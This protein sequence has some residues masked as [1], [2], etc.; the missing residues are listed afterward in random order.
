GPTTPGPAC[1]QELINKLLNEAKI[2]KSVTVKDNYG[3]DHLGIRF[4]I[5]PQ[6]TE[7]GNIIGGYNP[8]ITVASNG[9]YLSPS[10]IPND[11]MYSGGDRMWIQLS[12]LDDICLS[13]PPTNS[14]LTVTFGFVFEACGGLVKLWSFDYS[15][16]SHA[17]TNTPSPT[18]SGP[19]TGIP[20][21]PTVDTTSGGPG[22]NPYACGNGIPEP[23][24]ECGEAGLPN[25]P[26]G[27]TCNNCICSGTTPV[28][29]NN[30]AEGGEQCGEPTLPA[31]PAGYFCNNCRCITETP[32]GGGSQNI[33]S[34]NKQVRTLI[35]G[36]DITGMLITT[37]IED[38]TV[39]EVNQN[40]IIRTTRLNKGSNS[41]IEIISIFDRNPPYK[42]EQ[43][44]Y[45]DRGTLRKDIRYDYDGAGRLVRM[46]NI[47]TGSY[48]IFYNFDF[49]NR[50]LNAE[51]HIK[52]IYNG[53]LV[54]LVHH[55]AFS[56]S[57]N[58]GDPGTVLA[59][60]Y[61]GRTPE[62]LQRNLAAN[63]I[64]NKIYYKPSQE[65]YFHPTEITLTEEYLSGDIKKTYKEQLG[66]SLYKIEI[67]YK[68]PQICSNGKKVYQIIEMK[69]Y[70]DTTLI[71][72]E[73]IY[74]TNNQECG[75]EDISSSDGW[76]YDYVFENVNQHASILKELVLTYT[77]PSGLVYSNTYKKTDAGPSYFRYY[78]F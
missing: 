41:E 43:Y 18:Y 46:T 20:L 39:F 78:P 64:Y 11:L 37:G 17:P 13:N 29:G 40:N 1:P 71:D 73:T 47:V 72:S 52:F 6:L 54:E 49:N 31:C 14:I 42:I 74:L 15:C 75:I 58:H 25:C 28:C 2:I 19:G 10:S 48:N 5:P 9:A 4:D 63:K 32:G 70:L 30:I 65:Y 3:G 33:V 69:K 36:E 60:V 8:V 59:R 61:F 51:Q 7:G 56:Y 27:Q 55:W 12:K 23:G 76:L 22:T 16:N 68:D 35:T 77:L 38:E 66:V 53:G 50:A 62:E 45:L 21:P 34:N 67:F 24:E 57:V 26:A 44:R